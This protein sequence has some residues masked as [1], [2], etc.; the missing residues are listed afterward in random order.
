MRK[1]ATLIALVAMASVASAS[2]SY[3]I[4]NPD[5]TGEI[6]NYVTND[7]E[8]TTTSDW[9]S[10]QIVVIPDANEEIYQT[11][12]DDGFG[13]ITHRP[14]SYPAGA[15]GTVHE[16][17]T[18]VSDGLALG[19][20]GAIDFTMEAAVDLGRPA[21]EGAIING[22]GH[23]INSDIIAL[24]WSKTTTD[25]IGAPLHLARITIGDTAG[26]TWK[27]LIFCEEAGASTPAAEELSGTIVDGYMVP[28]PATMLVMLGGL[29]L[30][31][32]RRR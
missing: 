25:D 27:L 13:G 2:Y 8:F 7:I 32:R 23:M 29:G 16:W 20:S 31:A 4:T 30:L 22:P 19:G 14:T 9:L 12:L 5:N 6:S 1:I 11:T 26:G 21:A 28:E 3:E 18:H 24:M 10:A 17:D 15:A